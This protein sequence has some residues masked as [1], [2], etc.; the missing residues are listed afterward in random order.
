MRAS[1]SKPDDAAHA[2][3]AEGYAR[4]Q[5]QAWRDGRL[6]RVEDCVA[7]ETPV[8]LVYNGE[9]HVVMMAT[10]AD[11]EDFARGFSLSEGVVES[12]TEIEALEV[13]RHQGEG[14]PSC[15]VRLRIPPQRHQAL[16]R[17]R[18]NLHGR[19]GCGLCG[20]ETIADAIR[21]PRRVGAGVPVSVAALRRAQDELR[22]RQELNAL[23][24]AT[25]AAAWAAPDGALQ[26][27][28]EDVGRHNALDKLIGALLRA[29]VDTSRGFALVT[30]RASYEMAL[31]AAMAGMPLLAAISAPTAYAIRVAE[32]AGLTLIG[33]ARDDRFVIYAC[34]AR[35]LDTGP[36]PAEAAP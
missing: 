33:F 20:A 24:G 2:V 19:T 17:R 34:P 10:P 29:G 27:V 3:P 15:E 21:S 1:P 16:L 28:R 5:V 35:V 7:E 22:R 30:S 8:A 36:R 6:S 25:H 14:S 11:L 13:F 12:V 32:E 26:L 18:R 23:T 4:V 31:K 9:P